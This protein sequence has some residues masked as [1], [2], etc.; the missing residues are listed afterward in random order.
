MEFGIKMGKI[1]L[2]LNKFEMGKGAK[3]E[4]WAVCTRL[5]TTE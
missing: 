4:K 1:G 5:V 3:G 2:K